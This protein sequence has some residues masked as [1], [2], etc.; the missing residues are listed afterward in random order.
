MISLKEHILNDYANINDNN[1]NEGLLMNALTKRTLNNM[2]P[3]DLHTGILNMYDY[4]VDNDDIK[5]FLK[6]FPVKERLFWKN[7]HTLYTKNVWSV[8]DISIELLDEFKE[9]KL[10]S[11]FNVVTEITPE[12]RRELRQLIKKSKNNNLDLK[13]SAPSEIM[14]VPDSVTK[15][16]YIFTI[17]RTTGFKSL[18]RPIDK[19]FLIEVFNKFGQYTN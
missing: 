12:F 13:P 4:I 7:L 1:I 19:K 6:D 2:D 17:N 8:F 10:V 11:D 18:F 16:I 9:S 14:V 5:L 3:K 15:S